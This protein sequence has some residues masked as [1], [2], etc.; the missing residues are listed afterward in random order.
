MS[1]FSFLITHR[2]PNKETRT[3]LLAGKLT[4]LRLAFYVLAGAILV[5]AYITIVTLNNRLLVT[6]PASG[7]SITEG[8]V[9]AP[10]FIN[11]IL[12]ATDTDSA[13]VHLVYAG[14]MKEN[15][16]GAIVPELAERYS[17][18]P[19]GRVYTFTLRKK[20]F[21]SNG[22]PVTSSDVAFTIEKLQDPDINDYSSLYWQDV[23]VETP[24]ASTV[25]LS[26][27]TPDD[28]FLKKITVGILPENIWQGVADDAF[29]DPSL[30]LHPVGA[31]PFIMETLLS[32][33]SGT[34]TFI[35]FTRNK[36]YALGAP[37]LKTYSLA[38][39]PNQGALVSALN[40]GAIDMTTGLVPSTLT[41][42][43]FARGIGVDTIPSNTSVEVVRLSQESAFQNPA[44]L[45]IVD[46]YIDKAGIVAKVENGYGIPETSSPPLSL[47]DTIAA[48]AKVG[49][50]IDDSGALVRTKGKDKTPI[51]I[52][53]ATENDPEHT[54]ASRMLLD[55]LAAIGI[56][57]MVQPFDK[58][59]FK[60]GLMR[61]S[62]PFALVESGAR[63]SPAYTTAIALYTKTIVL[64]S[65]GTLHGASHDQLENNANRYSTVATWF[66][67][68]D[69]LWKFLVKK[70]SD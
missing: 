4:L 39:F 31:G 50:T 49:Y 36:K 43:A 34:P 1:F 35:T 29:G 16:D 46:Q 41:G 48:L 67:N 25:V 47:D 26:L 27:L 3:Q 20:L 65:N 32:D 54:T 6:V 55:Q 64:A 56:I 12:A 17:V 61:G 8:V 37:L 38:I 69:R 2:F 13:L 68:T 45:A 9:G 53:I 52:L 18:S 24:N 63:M 15:D 51:V 42:E 14:L 30:N 66:T 19:D 11:P 44:L 10:R 60:D 57:G 28:G 62:F 33:T 5:I 7:G 22:D 59:A 21:F 23:N 58:G 40:A 70:A